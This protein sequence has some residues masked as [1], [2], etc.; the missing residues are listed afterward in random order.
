[1]AFRAQVVNA[2]ENQG[3]YV[4][5]YDGMTF[6]RDGASA[7]LG[8]SGP[9]SDGKRAF[10]GMFRLEDGQLRD[11]GFD[12]NGRRVSRGVLPA[13]TVATLIANS[14]EKRCGKKGF[15]SL[16]CPDRLHLTVQK[17]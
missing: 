8:L 1:M 3:R 16:D 5:S 13:R 2:A 7:F 12:M 10:L 6:S 9:A 4:L 15:F 17:K 11:V 14:L